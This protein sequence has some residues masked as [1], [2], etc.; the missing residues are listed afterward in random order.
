MDKRYILILIIIFASA[1]NLY[2]IASN[3]D[4]I[5]SANVECGQYISIIPQGF[6]LYE[7]KT[8][9]VLVF[10][11]SRDMGVFIN[12]KINPQDT[13]K[14]RCDYIKSNSSLKLLSNGTINDNGIDIDSIYYYDSVKNRNYSVFYFEKFN[15]SF[16]VGIDGFNQDLDRNKTLDIITD[17]VDS[18][19]LNY[20]I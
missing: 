15:N 20:K 4:I 10:D 7:S 18:L 16:K 19:K 11:N 8:N 9:E 3:S 5:G 6:S 13:Y 1:I 14:N 17:I 12:S 2:F